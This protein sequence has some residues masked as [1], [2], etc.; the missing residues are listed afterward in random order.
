MSVDG[1]ERTWKVHLSGE[2]HSDW[3]ERIE[4]GAGEMAG[5]EFPCPSA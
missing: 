1:R 5:G 4:S 3:R 2:I